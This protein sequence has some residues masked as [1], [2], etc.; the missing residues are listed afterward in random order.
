MCLLFLFFI[1]LFYNMITVFSEDD[2]AY[3]NMGDDLIF[4]SLVEKL[5]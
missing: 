5:H 4:T 2:L 3:W 1:S